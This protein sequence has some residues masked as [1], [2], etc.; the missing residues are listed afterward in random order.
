MMDCFQVLDSISSFGFN[1]NLHR[2]KSVV[3]A[4]HHLAAQLAAARRVLEA[5]DAVAGRRAAALARALTQ[6]V[7]AAWR[8]LGAGACTRPLFGS[9]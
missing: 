3:A 6:S 1:F 2:Y 4:W 9:T 8:H 7:V 5:L